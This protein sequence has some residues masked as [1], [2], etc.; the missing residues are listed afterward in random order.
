[1]LYVPAFAKRVFHPEQFR[2]SHAGSRLSTCF[3]FLWDGARIF[4]L[5]ESISH[6]VA[7]ASPLEI[8]ILRPEHDTC[9]VSNSCARVL[10]FLL[11][12]VQEMPW[13]H[14]HEHLNNLLSRLRHPYA[15]LAACQ[16]HHKSA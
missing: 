14:L 6:A 3:R 4:Q 5:Y 2:T 9:I 11:A 15:S 7:E 1:H 10:Q 12:R 16:Q 13:P 8:Q